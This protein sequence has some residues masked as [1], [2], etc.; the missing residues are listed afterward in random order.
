MGIYV[1]R[2]KGIAFLM[3]YIQS[4]KKGRCFA[5]TYLNEMTESY[6]DNSPAHT[7]SQHVQEQ[8]FHPQLLWSQLCQPERI[9]NTEIMKKSY[10]SRLGS[11]V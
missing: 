8:I 6:K 3:A 2:Q 5:L 4:Q 1:N 10:S 7:M 11:N 9:E